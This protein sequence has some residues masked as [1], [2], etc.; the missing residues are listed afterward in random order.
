[1]VKYLSSPEGGAL[2]VS[3]FP[4]LESALP[5]L[6]L[7]CYTWLENLARCHVETVGKLLALLEE[8]M[9]GL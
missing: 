4:W 3:A 6:P 5:L 8:V 9:E 2:L 1:M 7:N